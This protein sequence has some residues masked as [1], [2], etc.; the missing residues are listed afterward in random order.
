MEAFYFAGGRIIKEMLVDEREVFFANLVYWAEVELV[1]LKMVGPIFAT[2]AWEE[3]SR[4]L[5]RL[6]EIFN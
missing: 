4:M 1:S 5:F 6:F 3:V 2:A